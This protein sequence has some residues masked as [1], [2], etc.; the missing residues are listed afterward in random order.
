MKFVCTIRTDNA[1]FDDDRCA[2]TARILRDV[3]D[4][5]EKNRSVRGWAHDANGNRVCKFAGINDDEI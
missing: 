3:A 5:V 4:Q 1:A 2:E